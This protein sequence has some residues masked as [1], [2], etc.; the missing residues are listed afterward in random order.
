MKYLLAAFIFL[1]SCSQKN[2]VSIANEEKIISVSMT[3]Y[4]GMMGYSGNIEVTKDSLHFSEIISTQ[5]DKNVKIDEI[6]LKYE[7]A[8][9]LDTITLDELST[10]QNGESNLAFDG[11]DTKIVIITNQRKLEIVNGGKSPQWTLL[12][13]KLKNIIYKDFKKDN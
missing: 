3:T 10:V 4:G 13:S 11:T 5:P 12:E 9:L 2:T 6:N 1:A 7:P 8:S